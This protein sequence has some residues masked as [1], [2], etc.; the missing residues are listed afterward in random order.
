MQDNEIYAG[1]GKAEGLDR[2]KMAVMEAFCNAEEEQIRD[3]K[4]IKI[5]VRGQL[6]M[7]EVNEIGDYIESIAGDEKNVEYNVE[8]DE[9]I[10]DNIMVTV[11]LSI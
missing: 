6:K 11:V 3:A 1:T 4:V 5:E 9:T 2:A 7:T 8:F 10:G